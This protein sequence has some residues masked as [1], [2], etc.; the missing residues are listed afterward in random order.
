MSLRQLPRCAPIYTALF[1][2]VF[3]FDVTSSA[4]NQLAT[5]PTRYLGS[6]VTMSDNTYPRD[7]PGQLLVSCL[8]AYCQCNL[9]NI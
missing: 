8:R 5:R 6:L 3:S 1:G 9:I 2:T 4:K 7:V